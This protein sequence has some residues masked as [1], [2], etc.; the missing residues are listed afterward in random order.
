M[1]AP[2]LTMPS[3]TITP[4]ALVRMIPSGAH[5]CAMA[6]LAGLLVWLAP[7][8]A[9]AQEA[10][11][12][13]IGTSLTAGFGLPENESFTGQLGAAL[14]AKGY[15][16]AI[17][18]AGVSGDTS[19][20]GRARLGWVLDDDVTHALVELGSNDALR[21]LDPAQTE[22][23]LTAIL[24]ELA[25]AEIP[26]L[27]AG[28]LAPRNLGPDYAAEF[29]GIYPRLAARDGVILYPFFLDGVAVDAA[30]NQADGIHPNAEGVAVIVERILPYVEE[31]LAQ[32][33]LNDTDASPEPLVEGDAP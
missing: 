33:A 11:L 8:H 5:I 18:N 17:I 7:S 4:Q 1:T 22:E 2:V 3:V 26:V 24:D 9:R 16:V 6:L 31:L 20:G 19:A 23:N 30:L 32:P 29:D 10:R 27:L 15:Q 21:G 13:A 14:E 25:A 12:L 28:M